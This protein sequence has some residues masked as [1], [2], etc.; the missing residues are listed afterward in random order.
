MKAPTGTTTT[1]FAGQLAFEDEAHRRWFLPHYAAWDWEV[2][3]DRVGAGASPWD[4]KLHLIQPGVGR[5]TVRVDEKARKSRWPDLLV[6]VDQMGTGD[7]GWLAKDHDAVIYAM[8]PAYRRAGTFEDAEA[9][10]VETGFLRP[11]LAQ[12][13][14]RLDRRTSTA[15]VGVS[16]NV[17]VPWLEV[18]DAGLGR[19]LV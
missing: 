3:E 16:D 8:F 4:V 2:L 9:W 5:R 18:L 12:N 13:E 1:S 6:E 10:W 19:R 15:G 14:W 11:W 17:V 7:G